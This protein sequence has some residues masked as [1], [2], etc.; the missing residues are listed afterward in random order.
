MRTNKKVICFL[1]LVLIAILVVKII[2]IKSLE[3]EDGSKDT[4]ILEGVGKGKSGD[5]LVEV[6]IKSNKIKHIEIIEHNET[7]GF[8][9]AMVQLSD[10]I[11]AKNSV[12][13]DIISG[14][15]ITSKGFISAVNNA[16]S[17]YDLQESLIEI[18][19]SNDVEADNYQSEILIIGGGGA[20][21]TAAI[22]AMSMG[23][24]SVTIIEK[25]PFGGGNTRMSGGEF[26]A[27]GNWVQVEEGITNDSVEL[28]YNDIYEGGYR[29]GKP[30]LIRI[31]AQSALDNALWLRDFVGVKYRDEQS[32]YGGHTVA[33]SLWPEGDG[34]SY[35]D[36]L[37]K[38]ALDMGVN[39]EYNTKAEEFIQN[40]EGRVIGVI[41]KNNGV[42]KRFYGNKG[43][44]LAT[45]GFGANVEMRMEYDTQWGRLDASIPTTNSPAIIGDGIVM[46]DNIGANLIGMGAIQLYP[47]NNPATGNYYFMDYARLMSNALLINKEGKRFVDEKETRDN[48][49]KATIFQPNATSYELIDSKVIEEMDLEGKYKD[50]LLRGYDQGVI[51]KGSL[52]ECSNFFD[53]PVEQV[54]ETV[55][56]YNKFAESGADLDFNR[57]KDLRKI[58]E[59][60]YIMFA[61][62]VSVHHTM[63]GV[64][65]DTSA[66]VMNEDGNRIEGLYATGEVTGGIHGGNRLGSLSIPDT[67]TFGRIAA[68]SAVNNEGVFIPVRNK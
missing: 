15:T 27:P 10:E 8:D 36:T 65:I 52:E 22:E 46:A 63:G 55:E 43:V 49:A 3:V 19:E 30:E 38:K 21:F 23:A 12:D 61:S 16:L 59:G 34:P 4:L 39:I 48:I 9:K 2:G 17:K 47:V 11:V 13:V 67:V 18:V 56:R 64:E 6:V 29:H 37:I 33:R 66:Q 31:L 25:M 53:I 1:L 26:A 50:E 28:F 44:I 54:K 40:E 51:F 24:S 60:P 42:E 32:W 68:R 14:S 5:I 57:T 62:V 58:E 41:A 7:P 45:G 20:G 35:I